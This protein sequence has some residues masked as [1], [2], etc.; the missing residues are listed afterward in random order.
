MCC[1]VLHHVGLLSESSAADLADKRLFACMNLQMLFKVEAL[2]VDKQSA[3][4]TALVVRPMIVHM[5]VEII[6]V[7]EYGVAFDAVQRPKVV[8][9]LILILANCGVV[10]G[11]VCFGG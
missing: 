2:R 10:V 11:G 6:Q 5:Y 3:D 9:N 1:D 7:G 4:R 8:L